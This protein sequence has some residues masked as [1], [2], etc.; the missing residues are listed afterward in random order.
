MGT[1]VVFAVGVVKDLAVRFQRQRFD[2]DFTETQFL[3]NTAGASDEHLAKGI[4]KA[5]DCFLDLGLRV[6]GPARLSGW[7]LGLTRPTSSRRVRE[8]AVELIM[9]EARAQVLQAK[10]PGSEADQ[11]QAIERAIARL[12]RAE[13]LDDPAPAALFDERSRYYDALGEPARADRDRLRAAQTAPATCHDWTLLGTT[14]LAAGDA[15][16]AEN[17]LRQAIRLDVTSFWTWFILGH[18]H[19]KQGRFLE[20]AGDF[21]VCSARGPAL[22]LGPL[23]PRPGPGQGGPAARCQERLRSRTPVGA[24]L[25][26]GNR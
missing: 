26:R 5:R 14:L 10:K 25:R 11:R 18:C 13:K 24:E 19:Y 23:Q 6:D 2:R 12:D 8:Q 15:P 9:L 4:A 21:A 17:A 20:A 22:R 1:A 3:L 16:G 7:V